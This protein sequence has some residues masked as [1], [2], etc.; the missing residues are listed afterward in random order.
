MFADQKKILCFMYG[1]KKRILWNKNKIFLV[2]QDY[3]GE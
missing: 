1:E 2:E 3:I